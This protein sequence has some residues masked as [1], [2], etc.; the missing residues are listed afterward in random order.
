MDFLRAS[1]AFLHFPFFNLDL[2]DMF[3]DFSECSECSHRSQSNTYGYP[4]KS[5]PC[6][7]HGLNDIISSDWPFKANLLFEIQN[8]FD[9]NQNKKI[10]ENQSDDVNEDKFIRNDSKTF[11]RN[12]DII[13]F[14]GANTLSPYTYDI[15]CK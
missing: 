4:E 13:A 3:L 12:R 5:F 6:S 9:T 10:Y 1:G 14:D 2:S 15:F 7:G 11:L 8:I